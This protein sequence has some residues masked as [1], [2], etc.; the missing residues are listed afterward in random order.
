MTATSVRPGVRRA[1]LWLMLVGGA[2]LVAAWPLWH[3][4]RPD[5]SG[6]RSGVPCDPRLVLPFGSLATVLTAASGF[7]LLVAAMLVVALLVRAVIRVDARERRA[8]RE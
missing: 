1:I 5:Q 4:V 2:A 7:A 8:R 3:V 6:C